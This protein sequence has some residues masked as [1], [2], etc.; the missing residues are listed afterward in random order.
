MANFLA[1]YSKKK[2]MVPH[3]INAALT[4]F[5]LNG[6]R[7]LIQVEFPGLIFCVD[8]SSEP[9]VLKSENSLSFISG[10][11]SFESTGDASAEI[12]DVKALKRLM[13][14]EGLNLL[15]QLE[16]MFSLIH[17]S[18]KEHRLIFANDKFGMSPL[19]VYED[20]NYLLVSNEYQPLMA[21][22][23]KK[24]LKIN[25]DAVAEF[26]VFGTTLGNH[27]FFEKI[28]KSEAANSYDVTTV[29]TQNRTYWS[30]PTS[31][32]PAIN[33]EQMANKFL[34]LFTKVNREYLDSKGV[35]ICLLSAGADSRLIL[36]TASE[37]QRKRLVFYTSNL[38][39]LEGSQ[40]MDV[41]GATT[42]ANKFGLK[43]E[44][45]KISFYETEFSGAYFDKERK[46]RIRQVY[47]GWHG[48][49]L[50]G[51]YV[52]L[53]APIKQVPLYDEVQQKLKTYFSL[54]F[55][56]QLKNHPHHTLMQE[57]KTTN[58]EVNPFLFLLKQI[59]VSFFTNIYGGSRGHWLQPYQLTN[60]GFSPFWDSRILQLL[61]EIPFDELKDYKFYNA[62]FKLVPTEFT[63]IPS[64]SPL[65]NRADSVIPK[66]N[67]GLEP[68]KNIPNTHHV[69]YLECLANK[70]IWKRGF[71][72]EPKL[73]SILNEEMNALTK[74]WLD[75][76]VW[77][78]HYF[79]P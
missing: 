37:E 26:F 35:D 13:E 12:S 4:E 65:T 46:R 29:E 55:R 68:K 64:N 56:L 50:L 70:V 69:A 74:Q 66:L 31:F 59:S 21:F 41:I 45:E 72:N 14:K 77:H 71:Y 8:E 76:E 17:Y 2:E 57:F 79:K 51:G 60:H 48:G 73:K 78:R 18:E 63:S 32:N 40:D 1:I 27:T 19:F 62:V 36:A 38:S 52:A 43:H 6:D 9:S 67:T 54:R 16:G 61:L 22:I 47:G 25:K 20:K 28:K 30:P 58:A 15:A 53:A 3:E 7:A 11:V 44:V 10:H 34:S 5:S 24:R 42:L 23:G 49:E 33:I 39:V 75:F